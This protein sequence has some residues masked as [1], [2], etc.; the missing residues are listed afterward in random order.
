DHPDPNAQQSL[1]AK[2]EISGADY[3]IV[4]DQRVILIGRRPSCDIHLLEDSVSTAHAVIFECDGQRFVRDL[5]SRTGTFVNGVSTR[6]H[7]LSVGDVIRVGDTDLKYLANEMA[8]AVVIDEESIA[9]PSVADTSEL[10]QPLPPPEPPVDH[11]IE[12]EPVVPAIDETPIAE[13]KPAIGADELLP[14]SVGDDDAPLPIEQE[15]APSAEELSPALEQPIEEVPEVPAVVDESDVVRPELATAPSADEQPVSMEP[16]LSIPVDESPAAP[17]S[18]VDISQPEVEPAASE[19]L[20]VPMEEASINEE[21]IASDERDEISISSLAAEAVSATGH[22]PPQEPEA[23]SVSMAGPI[24]P[25]DLTD[26]EIAELPPADQVIPQEIVSEPVSEEAIE[27]ELA[28]PATQQELPAVDLTAEVDETIV[29]PI[30]AK[31]VEAELPAPTEVEPPLILAADTEE[32]SPLGPQP[33]LELPTP[34]DFVQLPDSLPAD[35]FTMGGLPATQAIP[36]IDALPSEDTLTLPP[37]KKP[38]LRPSR[39]PPLPPKLNFTAPPEEKIAPLPEPIELEDGIP[40]LAPPAEPLQDAPIAVEPAT[41]PDIVPSAEIAEVAPADELQP[42]ESEPVEVIDKTEPTPQS[43]LQS[44]EDQLALESLAAPDA[45][46]SAAQESTLSDTTF[47]RAVREFVGDEIGDLVETPAE[48]PA[49]EATA[50]QVEPAISESLSGDLPSE[51]QVPVDELAEMEPLAAEVD[52]DA[53]AESALDISPPAEDPQPVAAEQSESA[54]APIDT[55]ELQSADEVSVSPPADVAPEVKE[56]EKQTPA[57]RP[58]VPWGANQDNFLGGVPLAMRSSSEPAPVAEEAVKKLINQIDDTAAAAEAAAVKAAKRPVPQVTPPRPKRKP[59]IRISDE[60][61]PESSQR[62][63][64]KT[65]FD[66]LAFSPLRDMDVFSQTSPQ[67]P[68]EP[69]ADVAKTGAPASFEKRS[70]DPAAEPANAAPPGAFVVKDPQTPDAEPPQRNRVLPALQGQPGNEIVAEATPR[71]AGELTE[72]DALALRKSYL[73]RAATLVGIMIVVIAITCAAIYRFFGVENTVD[74]AITYKNLAAL[75]RLERTRFQGEMLRVLADD[76]TRRIARNKLHERPEPDEGFLSDQVQYLKVVDR[77]AFPE[78]RPDTL[79]IHVAGRDPDNDAA[80]VAAM[81]A[82]QYEANHNLSDLA[83]RARRNLDEIQDS[84]NRY[85]QDLA[86]IDTQIETLRLVDEARPTN[87]QV[88]QLTGEVA[89]LEQKWN[90]AVAAAKSAEA[91]LNRLKSEPLA[92]DAGAASTSIADDEKLKAMQAALDELQ[93]KVSAA[94]AVSS[95]QSASAKR[96]LDSALDAFQKQVADAQAT[97]NGNPELTAYVQAAQKLQETT[98]QLTDDLIHRQESQFARLTE[99][100]ARL[101]ERMETRRVEAWQ[102]DKQLQD[103]TEQQAILTRQYNAAVGGG[104]AKEAD[105]KKAALD[106]VKNMIKARQELLPGDTFYADA[107]QQIQVIIDSTQKDIAEDRRRTEQLLTTLQSSFVSGPTIEK[108]PQEQKAL[109]AQMKERLDRINAARQQY[110]QAVDANASDGDAQIKSQ[111]ATLQAAIDARHKQLVE[112][113]L[114]SMKDQQE[115]SR[116]AA[117]KPKEEELAKAKEAEA[118]ASAAYFAKHKELRDAQSKIASSNDNS[119]QLDELLRRKQSAEN[120]LK[121]GVAN[122][123]NKKRAV[124]MAVEPLQPGDVSVKAGNDRR[125]IYTFASGGAILAIFSV[126]IFWTLHSASHHVHGPSIQAADLQPI[127]EP[128]NSE[129]S[130]HAQRTSDGDE[131]E[132]E[133]AI[134]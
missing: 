131:E 67:V 19:E 68:S 97:L 25:P 100:K 8:E 23:E 39:T 15:G 44:A 122:L 31:D 56:P 17:E 65:G 73:R 24:E 129:P 13:P 20:A 116:L 55:L 18:A 101:N 132:H 60:P 124:E 66:G 126:L 92:P 85:K 81:L 95:E 109:A 90:T 64:L 16:Q 112:Q 35:P 74:G 29:P 78:A 48:P 105:D 83:S 50:E 59:P 41:E 40:T 77:A 63:E 28:Q 61:P 36:G 70:P 57:Q 34:E 32:P 75:T 10:P 46:A 119:R 3:P 54:E 117:I 43:A 128:A 104:L 86:Q 42:V 22:V 125:L 71:I 106:L 102:N 108:L 21:P 82:A 96:M 110:N 99:L 1:P 58:R 121:A 98:R 33:A 80:R 118:E 94:K 12:I 76:T 47:D 27:L 51:A 53:I 130:S 38:R 45:P 5:G 89:E 123:D 93:T 79:V 72:A 134:I 107:I 87:D 113:N 4:I 133:P 111:M 120:G 84:I 2:L 62:N 88:K 30:S 114:K 11:A 7:Q 127:V 91:E 52:E 103:L 69:S 26:L 9:E 6:Q 115:Q 37:L 49:P 14:I